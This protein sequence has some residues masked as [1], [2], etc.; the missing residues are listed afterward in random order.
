MYDTTDPRSTLSNLPTSGASLDRLYEAEYGLFYR[1]PP[2]E[3]DAK[4]KS[5]YVRG[6]DFVVAYSEAEPGATFERTGQ[7]DE[8]MVLLPDPDTPAIASAAGQTEQSGGYALFIMPP[9]DSRLTLDQG[10]RVVRIF[11]TQSPDLNGKCSNARAYAKQHDNIPAFTP[12]PAPPNG[13]RI[14]LYSLDV[15]IDGGRFGR[16][17]RCTTLMVN[18]PAKQKGPRDLTKVSPHHHD[19]FEQGSL[20][21]MGIWKHHMRW[22]W[23]VDMNKWHDD[24]HAEVESPSVTVIPAQV[25]HTST[26]HS[27]LNQLVDIFAPPRVDFSLK[28]GWVLNGDEYPLPSNVAV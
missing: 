27:D 10:G 11:S 7:P 25:I 2:T 14:R 3:D 17:W 15:P 26:W 6:Q 9:G 21:L 23:A 8:Y 16:I 20:A 4:G 19:D 13:F 12:W 24:V 5:W 1:E 18:I 22:P 28:P